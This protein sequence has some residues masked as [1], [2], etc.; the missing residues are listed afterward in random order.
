MYH[1]KTSI[2]RL[3]SMTAVMWKSAWAETGLALGKVE[4]SI[5]PFLLFGAP[6][7]FSE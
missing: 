7:L 2:P 1:R 5:V 6:I 4:A 3:Y